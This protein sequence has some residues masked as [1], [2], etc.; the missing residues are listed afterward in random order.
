MRT[1]RPVPA[2][3]AGS[4]Q[5]I[6]LNPILQLQRSIG[7]QATGRRLLA[8]TTTGGPRQP[9][10]G[11]QRKPGPD[12]VS[13][14][15]TVT[16]IQRS[17]GAPAAQA[18]NAVENGAYKNIAAAQNE[19]EQLL[20]DFKNKKLKF[21]DAGISFKLQRAFIYLREAW[22]AV[23]VADHASLRTAL[24]AYSRASKA[25]GE[26]VLLLP[27]SPATEDARFWLEQLGW[28]ETRMTPVK[29]GPPPPAQA[30]TD[31]RQDMERQID[32]WKEACRA[33]IGEFVHAELASQIDALSE[34]N[35]NSFFKA[36]VGNTIWAAA[37]FVPAGV[38]AFA[39]SMIG[40]AIAS[41]PTVPQKGAGKGELAR[42][43]DQLHA[44]IEK[45]HEKLNA[46]LESHA[47]SLLQEHPGVTLEES[48]RLFLEASFRPDM[49]R[50]GPPSIDETRVRRTMRDSAA[51]T[52][53]LLREVS[54]IEGPVGEIRTRSR[55]L[56]VTPGLR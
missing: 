50:H 56:V 48:M 16:S 11:L 46:Q 39:V 35:W 41:A 27:R 42:I 30:V 44:Y 31:L 40:I 12:P 32:N 18:G 21:D 24:A 47:A 49:V 22:R 19:L 38:P 10:T 28:L 13:E 26:Y 20:A 8:Y 2:L 9:A 34:G 25:V 29:H 4:R 52:L 7:N 53:A 37:A 54:K 55:G 15:A 36:L 6:A 14:R 1:A 17:P 23:P 5:T 43:E 33:G 51:Y 3:P 45:I